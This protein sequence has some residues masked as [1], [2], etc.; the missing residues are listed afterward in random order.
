MAKK[1]S[2]PKYVVP[3]SCE[4]CPRWKEVKDRIRVSTILSEALKR[5]GEKLKENDFKASV[6]DYLKLMELEREFENETAKEIRVSWIEPAAE[7]KK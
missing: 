5:F 6:G 3:N 1:K 4:E 2:E 7:S